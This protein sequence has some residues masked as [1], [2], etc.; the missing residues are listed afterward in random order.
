MS[1]IN[2]DISGKVAVVTGAGG[3][4]CSVLAK[5]LAKQGVLVAL[6]DIAE[7]KA[8]AIADEIIQDGG[9]AM[10]VRV[11][12]LNKLSVQEACDKVLER[13]GTVDIL[14]NGAGGNKAAA[15]TSDELPFF[16]L[17]DDAINWVFNLNLVGTILPTQ[18]FGKVMADNGK[19]NII[20][21]SSM[22]AF[23]PLTRTMAY[24][25]AKAGISNFTQWMAVHFAQEY[26]PNIRV[27]AIAPG[28]L[29]TQQ[30]YYLLVDKE[31]GER[32]PGAIRLST[33]RLWDATASLRS[34]W[35]R[36]F[37]FARRRLPL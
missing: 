9:G 22:S 30:N 24:S 25:A 37:S 20:N 36:L 29:L 17:P 35:A 31:T 34:W 5:N 15:T 8:Q 27:N 33:G 21:I 19:G 23:K 7:D 11:D 12:V 16:D 13:F 28:F 32:T 26:S 1:K 14:V 4:L 10:A 3:I 6:L 2:F 18:V